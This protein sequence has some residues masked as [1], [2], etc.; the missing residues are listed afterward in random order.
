MRFLK[1]LSRDVESSQWPA[2]SKKAFAREAELFGPSTL[3]GQEAF[4]WPQEEIG[5]QHKETWKE[6]SMEHKF[7]QRVPHDKNG[8]EHITL[9]HDSLFLV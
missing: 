5:L 9:D 3:A 2:L 7:T 6:S 8:T 1:A 4:L